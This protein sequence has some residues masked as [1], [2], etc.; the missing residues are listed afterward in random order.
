MSSNIYS[1]YHLACENYSRLTIF[2]ETHFCAGTDELWTVKGLINF[3]H[4]FEFK[5]YNKAIDYPCIHLSI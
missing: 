3:T 5:A 4:C 2:A 1:L